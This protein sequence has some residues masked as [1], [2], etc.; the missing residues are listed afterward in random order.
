MLAGPAALA[1]TA[2]Q[3]PAEQKKPDTFFAGTIS[4]VSQE[5]IS[6]SRTVL[7]KIEHRAFRI[8]PETK[9]EGKLR[10]KV[11]VTVRYVTAEDGDVATQIVVRPVEPKKK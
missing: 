8:T 10:A 5:K 7:G 4:E 11:R 9:V 3:T 1:T 2:Q 6:V